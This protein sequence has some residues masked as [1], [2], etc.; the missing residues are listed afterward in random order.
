MEH[1][2]RIHFDLKN[3]VQLNVKIIQQFVEIEPLKTY[4]CLVI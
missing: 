4:S 1:Q 3:W 2:A